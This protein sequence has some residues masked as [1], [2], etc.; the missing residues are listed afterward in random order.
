[1]AAIGIVKVIDKSIL[2]IAK[3]VI[4]PNPIMISLCDIVSER[5]TGLDNLNDAED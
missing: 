2:R 3:S 5:F 4:S 1:V